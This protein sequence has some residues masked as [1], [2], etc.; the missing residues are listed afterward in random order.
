[1]INK[2]T[3]NELCVDENPGDV[4]PPT[5][6]FGENDVVGASPVDSTDSGV[7]L[8]GEDGECV[9]AYTPITFGITTNEPALCRYDLEIKE[10]DEMEFD[11][12]GNYYKYN[13][14]A[15]FML[16]D[17]SHGESQGSNWT[18]DLALYIKCQDTHG[19]E[20]PGIYTV[21]MCVYQG[22]DKKAPVIVATDPINNKLIS[23]DSTSQNVKIITNELST[24]RWDS[25]DKI[26]SSMNYLMV[27]NDTLKKPSSMHGYV[28]T[29]NLTVS[30]GTNN[31]Y[32][33]CGD[34]PWLDD[35]EQEDNTDERNF[36][37]ESYIFKLNKPDKK[38][39]IDAIKPDTDF[40][41][42]TKITTVE[43]KIETSGGGEWHS[44]SYSF[45]GY[46][47]MIKLFETGADRIHKQP[48]N[49]PNG[50]K[51]I[52]VECEDE[53]GDFARASTNFKIIHDVSTPQVARI[54]QES[55]QLHII[56]TEIS[57][58]KYSTQTCSFN[59]GTA[60]SA[61]S[62]FNHELPVI[63]GQ[64]YFIKCKDE[65]GNV[66]SQCSIK[67]LAL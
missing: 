35:P 56:T 37:L 34:Q 36:N 44:C 33:R 2:G 1:M 46:E 31:Y 49:L 13:H 52:Y 27:C 47:N 8:V 3:D 18:G 23:F 7:T 55:G 12:G 59:W 25:T 32:I 50:G 29:D 53:T 63:H 19:I 38:I 20:S 16:P 30:N 22:P 64:N 10:F 42:P 24:C 45:S 28:C 48:L 6:G 40:E 43:L 67:V 17:P 15:T 39:E 41:T 58:C 5:I 54:W 66:P 65:F 14:T 61:G 11:L 60:E 26:Y 4:T 21:S 57:E 51:T 62:G 9:D